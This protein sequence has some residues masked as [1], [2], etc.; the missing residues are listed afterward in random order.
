MKTSDSNTAMSDPELIVQCETRIRELRDVGSFTIRDLSELLS[1][2]Q[3]AQNN[4][5][6]TVKHRDHNK[7]VLTNTKNGDTFTSTNQQLNE[8]LGDF[9]NRAELFIIPTDRDSIV[10]K[11]VEAVAKQFAIDYSYDA[12]ICVW[13]GPYTESIRT[14][15]RTVLN[16]EG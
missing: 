9:L 5:T 3:K 1:R 16:P 7:I 2:F 10:E 11:C 14:A 8:E 13:K 15:L 12:K 6:I 4:T